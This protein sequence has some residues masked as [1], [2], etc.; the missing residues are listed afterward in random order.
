MVTQQIVP[1]EMTICSGQ[2]NY[3]VDFYMTITEALDA[4]GTLISPVVVIDAQVA[5]L[6]ADQL[7]SLTDRMPVLLLDATE[8]EKTLTGVAKVIT[9]LQQNNGTRQTKLLAIGGGIIQDIAAFAAFIYYRGLSWEFMPTTLLAMSDSCIGAKCGV[10]FGQYKNQLGMFHAPSHVLICPAFIDTLS[11]R[12]LL[13]GYGEIIKL[14][15]TGSA[16]LFHDLA[17]VITADGFRTRQL[18]RF[19]AQSLAVKKAVIEVDE[20]D[21]GV[22]NTLNYGHTFGH[23]LEALTQHEV[24]HGIA[25]VWGMDLV[26]YLA[27]RMGRLPETVYG[28]IHD[29]FTRHFDYAISGPL[30]AEK[31]IACT[32]R[33][34]KVQRGH[35]NLALLEDYGKLTMTPV[36]FDDHLTTLV[37]EYLAL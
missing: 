25:V 30:S 18:P 13:S 8:E 11:D 32:K 19:I 22:R 23:A 24:P 7:A 37:E 14:H 29:F 2:G 3:T 9:F 21:R 6:Y 16:K 33:D 27:F 5:A 15:I 4:L 26:N 10:N 20:Y 12:D 35:L 1:A 31:L 34:K 17:S 36:P 28:E